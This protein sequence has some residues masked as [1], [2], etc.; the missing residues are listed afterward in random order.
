[1]L[2]YRPHLYAG[3]QV[4]FQC[5]LNQE[6]LVLPEPGMPV[7]SLIDLMRRGA[8]TSVSATPSYWRRLIA[9]S[10]P[11]EFAALKLSQITLGGEAADQPMLD[12][13][14]RYFPEARLVHI[15]ATSELGRCFSVDDRLA[16]FPVRLL[17]GP[18]QDGVEIKVENDELHVR[19]A[20]A[21]L[22][23][24]QGRDRDRRGRDWMATGDLVER[25]GD[26][27]IFA[28]RRDELINVGGNKVRPLLVEQV[29]QSVP[30]VRDARV[31]ARNSSLVGQM[32]ACEFVPEPGLEPEE[33]TRLIQKTCLERLEEYQRPRFIQPVA[34]I[35][36]SEAD[37]RIRM[38][39]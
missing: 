2:T 19:S 23:P 21:M 9:L 5:L 13:L 32:V 8:V 28:G 7:G 12:T 24:Q 36:L 25:V 6:T 20:N 15:Y 30:G 37:K 31:F 34:T 27:Y 14:T 10:R 1:L 26:R 38:P 18:S 17:D 3:L 39:G 4:F 11:E 29:V 16:G 33:V 22:G 35:A